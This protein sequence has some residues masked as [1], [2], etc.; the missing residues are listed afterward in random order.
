MTQFPHDNFVKDYL[1]S[2]LKNYGTATP[3]QQIAPEVKEVD[4]FFVPN[5]QVPT[6]SET[7]GLLGKLAQSSCLLEVYRNPVT[8]SEIRACL[9]KL[10]EIQSKKVSENETLPTLWILTPTLSKRILEEFGAIEQVE[11]WSKGVY[12]CS[13]GYYLGIVVIHQLPVI[14]DTLWLRILGKGT[15]Q[16]EA[17]QELNNLPAT[18]PRKKSILDLVYGLLTVLE[19]N[20]KQGLSL[21]TEEQQLIMKLAAVY[22]EKIEQ[23]KN[24]GREEGVHQEAVLLVMRLLKRKLGEIP[25]ETETRLTNLSTANLENLAEALLDFNSFEDLLNWLG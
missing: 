22:R 2:L 11:R 16:I 17:I 8:S 20:R 4:V 21:D 14:S 23:V 3:G 12:I 6:T 19:I 10:F 25:S 15:V 9:T 18:N 13:S 1:P 24:E 5:K 7:L